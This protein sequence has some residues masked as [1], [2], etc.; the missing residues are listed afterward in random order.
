VQNE[1]CAVTHRLLQYRRGKCVVHQDGNIAGLCADIVQVQQR[2]G[3][4]RR[5]LDHHQTGVGSKGM[6]DLLRADPGDLH[7]EQTVVEQVVGASVDRTNRDHVPLARGAHSEQTSRQRGHAGG[8][9]DCFCAAL[10]LGQSFL[11]AGDRR[12]PQPAVDVAAAGDR[13]T[14]GR[15]RL[16]GV[17]AG[18]DVCQRVG[19]GQVDGGHMDAE[20]RKVAPT[21]MHCTSL[22]GVHESS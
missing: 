21:G 10:E 12:V 14:P 13:S 15:E 11:E 19:R 22:E 4:I 7:A 1:D 2:Q 3:G 20:T 9:R 17:T 6:L 18:L 16:V 8:E 5:R